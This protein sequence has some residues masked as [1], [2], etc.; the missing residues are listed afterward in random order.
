MNRLAI[1]QRR[2]NELYNLHS[3]SADPWIVWGY[4]NHVLEVAQ[5]AEQLATRYQAN[6]EF[7]IAGAL[8]HDIGDAVNPRNHPNHTNESLRLAQTLLQEARYKNDEIKTIVHEI[9]APHSCNETLPTALEGKILATADAVTHFTT[10]FFL[11][12]GWKHMGSSD[13]YSYKQFVLNKLEKNYN[14]KIFFDDVRKE[15]TPRYL[16]LMEVYSHPKKSA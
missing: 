6:V 1:I 14:R 7:C 3:P 12:F 13:F 5:V 11:Y 4:P 10:D 9:I 16:A 8:L 2:V 15:M